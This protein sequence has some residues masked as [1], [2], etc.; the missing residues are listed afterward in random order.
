MRPDLPSP[1]LLV[2]QAAWLAP[3]RARLL[4]YIGIARRK[5]VLDL[6]AGYGTV[7][8]E[9]RRRASGP[10]IALDRA[11]SALRTGLLLTSPENGGIKKSVGGNATRL[12]FVAH[13]FEVVF[14][15]LTLLWLSPLDVA[16][17]EIV[18]VLAPNGV[19]VALEPDYAGMIESP[20]T[21]A[22][23]DLWLTGLR[24]AGAE[25]NIGRILPEKLSTRGLNVRVTLLDTLVPP[26]PARFELLRGL[27]LTV[28][29][30][31]QLRDIETASAKLT[32]PWQQIAH[33]PFFLIIATR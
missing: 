18:R 10:V 9:L 3:A 20:P 5:R 22:T 8:G 21:I 27:S 11:V 15:Q 23:H 6:G 29:E 13:S 31:A 12:P 1:D 30:Q 33:L 16:L 19:L 28:E 25:P 26:D 2:Q 14:S 4:R 32:P 24:R 17:D 7:T